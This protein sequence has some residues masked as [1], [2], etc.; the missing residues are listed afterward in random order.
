MSLALVDRWSAPWP[1][2]SRVVGIAD[3]DTL[4]VKGLRGSQDP[5]STASIAQIRASRSPIEQV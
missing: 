1:N 4:S 5:T 2:P 3:G